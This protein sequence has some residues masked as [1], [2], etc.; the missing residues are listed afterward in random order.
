MVLVKGVKYK[1]VFKE[2]TSVELK[3]KSV[4]SVSSLVVNE[5]GRD[6]SND[7]SA[8][9]EVGSTRV[10]SLKDLRG[11]AGPQENLVVMKGG[12]S[13]GDSNVSDTVV[14][15][16]V[17]LEDNKSVERDSVNSKRDEI[18]RGDELKVHSSL[19]ETSIEND[20]ESKE[21]DI[22]SGEDTVENPTLVISHS[23]ICKNL[24]QLKIGGRIERPKVNP[25]LHSISKLKK[26]YSQGFYYLLV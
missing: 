11:R 17:E 14:P 7:L 5:I 22:S 16:M 6:S 25:R 2:H 4:M 21:V 8:G 15:K 18:F 10:T 1:V 20:V 12:I 24:K 26:N 3:E 19:S 13:S 23:T 9:K